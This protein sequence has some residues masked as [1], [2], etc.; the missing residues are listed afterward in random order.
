MV[1]TNCYLKVFLL[2]ILWKK[3]LQTTWY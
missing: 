1:K 2:N 3:I